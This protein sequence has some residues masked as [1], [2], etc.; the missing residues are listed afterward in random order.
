MEGI[1]FG[2]QQNCVLTVEVRNRIC[3]TLSGG[4][5]PVLHNVLVELPV[6]RLDQPHRVSV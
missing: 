6:A 5:Y 2:L 4:I 1:P 3:S